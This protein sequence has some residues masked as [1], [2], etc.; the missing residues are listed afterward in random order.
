M[1]KVKTVTVHKAS[2][3][4]KLITSENIRNNILR[5][6]I[7]GYVSERGYRGFEVDEVYY[8]LSISTP[9]YEFDIEVMD[10]TSLAKVKQRQLA[11]YNALHGYRGNNTVLVEYDESEGLYPDF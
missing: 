10:S 11:I 3:I 2:E 1:A 5:L 6:Y 4:K 9:D 8:T 7:I